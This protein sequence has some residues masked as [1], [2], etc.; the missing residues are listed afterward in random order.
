MIRW[1]KYSITKLFA[2]L[3]ILVEGKV[4]IVDDMGVRGRRLKNSI[5][6]SNR[7]HIGHG[8]KRSVNINFT[9]DLKSCGSISVKLGSE[10]SQESFNRVEFLQNRIPNY[11]YGEVNNGTMSM[12][13]LEELGPNG[14]KRIFATVL[15]VENKNVHIIR[16]SSFGETEMV[17]IHASEYP[18]AIAEPSTNE[19][20]DDRNLLNATTDDE[21]GDI[22]DILVIWSHAAECRSSDL[23]L[24]CALNEMTRSNMRGII[25]LGVEEANTAYILSGIETQLR[26]VFSY[27]EPTNYQEVDAYDMLDFITLPNDG[28]LDDVHEKRKKFGADLVSF[29][30]DTRQTCGLGW[31]GPKKQFMFSVQSWF[32]FAGHFSLAHEVGHN[33]GCNH[34]RV[35]ENCCEDRVNVTY[36]YKDPESRYRSIMAYDCQHGF[37]NGQKGQLCTRIQRFSNTKYKFQNL[38]IGDN[39]TDCAS[40]INSVR[41]IVASYYPA[42]SN[43]VIANLTQQELLD[44]QNDCI[45]AGNICF[46]DSQCCSFSCSSFKCKSLDVQ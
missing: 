13:I 21:T 31:I 12:N 7:A 45:N 19:D 1:K 17:T 33:Y 38:P 41:S 22:I 15:D 18:N 40:Q 30:V 20:N 2:C 27:R 14:V 32:C 4:S 29:V 16:P 11:W 28:I 42:L 8:K 37:C 25:Q 39:Q 35:A 46:K 3:Y 43:E 34:D 26:L 24:G 9:E 36:G 44:E 10:Y 5:E 23:P 6:A